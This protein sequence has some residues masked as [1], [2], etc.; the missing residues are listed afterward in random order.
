M[1]TNFLSRIL[2]GALAAFL[3]TTLGTLAHAQATRTWISGVGD[4]ANPC[5][6]TAPGKTFAGAIS[7]TA[8]GG[9]INVLDPG[10]FGAV[11][12]TKSI[13][14]DGSGGSLAGIN[15]SGTNAIIINAAATDTITLRNLDINGLGSGLNGVSILSAAEVNIENCVIR[16][17]AQKGVNIGTGASPVRVNIRNCIISRCND[18]TNGGAVYAN[19]GAGGAVLTISDSSLTTSLYGFKAKEGIKAVLENCII[20][21]HSSNGIVASA[22]TT[23]TKVSINASV[24]SDCGAIG[25]VSTNANSTIRI[26]GNTIFNNATGIAAQSGGVLITFGNNTIRGNTTDAAAGTPTATEILQ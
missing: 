21:G 4:D 1:K 22:T 16:G 7:K 18:A 9:E 19:P 5:S 25:A 11:T 17:F 13:T 20:T 8:A 2:K 23:P 10:G 26:S 12:I 24:I 15:V 3:A 6:R 14:L